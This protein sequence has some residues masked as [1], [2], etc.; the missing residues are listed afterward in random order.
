MSTYSFLDVTAAISG[1]GGSI[2]IGNDAGPSEEGITVTMNDNKNT[3]TIGADGSGMHSLHAG[4]SGTITVRLLKT[5]PTNKLLQSMY[6]YQVTSSAN[7]G[8]NTITIRDTA[9]GDFVT[10][11][12]C[13]FRKMPDNAYAKDGN[14][15]EWAW[16]CIKIA[17]KLGSGS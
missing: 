13:A 7:H 6:S 8:Q 3:M 1:P 14:M 15:M 5:S 4:N 2:N 11:S 17:Q 16:D 12:Y 9:R 10:A